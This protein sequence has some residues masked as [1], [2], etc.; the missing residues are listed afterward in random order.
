MEQGK[1]GPAERLIQTALTYMD[2]AYHNRPGIV[3]RDPTSAIGVKWEMVTDSRTVYVCGKCKKT[4]FG[5][6]GLP[7]LNCPVCKTDG[8]L[9]L[10][11]REE[12]GS[13]VYRLPK[14]AAPVRMGVR[15]PDN[16]VM[17]HGR[18]VGTYQPAG[19]FNAVVA[20]LYKQIAEVY[21]LDEEFAARWASYAFAQEH[22]DFKCIIAAFMLVQKRK[23]DPIREGGKILFYD[24]DYRDVGEAMLLLQKKDRS[25]D[26]KMMLRVHDI[27]AL[28]EVAAINREL[29]FGKSP[30]KPFLGRWPEVVEKWLTYR[31][32]NPKLLTGLVGSGFRTT[33]MAL[34]CKVGYKPTDP[35]FFEILRWKQRQ[36]DDGRRSLIIG[37]EVSKAESW[38][39]LS[40]HDICLRIME[41]K[42]NF[43]RIVGMLPKGRGLTRAIVA[44]AIESG[45]MG[46]RD[47]VIYAP[48]LEELGLLEQPGIKERYEAALK[49]V[50]DMR[51]ANVA[52]R[53]KSTE[54]KEKL[55]Q[56]ADVALQK[57]VA[58]VVKNIRVYV[59]VDKSSSMTTSIDRAKWLLTRFLQGFPLDKLHVSIFNTV[60]TEVPIKH[61]SAAGVEQAFSKHKAD[62]GTNYAKGV[63]VLAKYKPSPDEDTIFIFVGD[64]GQ[65]PTFEVAVQQSGLR[66][67][68]FG[69]V[70]VPG[71]NSLCVVNTAARLGIPCFLI[72]EKTFEDPYAIP[73]TMR[74]LIAST[75]VG[76]V[77]RPQQTIV[78][79]TLIDVI[80]KTPLLQKPAWA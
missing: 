10:Q 14:N 12:Q 74:T 19:L 4:I 36:A 21:K 22:R 27:L 9:T 57:Q 3:T 65:H 2:H 66:P 55:E 20:W 32:E 69:L 67:M 15:M 49:N 64:E 71:D 34:S 59:I 37:K 24:D 45:A 77:P 33:V 54:N 73:R 75:P 5:G 28:P 17:E 53:M 1:H 16:R 35:K 30:R 51:A 72:D 48:T 25:F 46:N 44:A 79:E 11:S 80:Q 60:G 6:D 18:Q 7:N 13:V 29:G 63:E 40:E 50:D 70:R 31:T 47:L 43:K 38:E 8:G 76:Q 41:T 23:G 26:A 68:A 39:G 62:G 52:Q 58:E 61:A 56:A 42:P 78:R